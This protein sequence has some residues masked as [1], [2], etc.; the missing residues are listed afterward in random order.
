MGWKLGGQL[1]ASQVR[2]QIEREFDAE[3]AEAVAAAIAS[4]R[5]PRPI[6]ERAERRKSEAAERE[7]LL[8]SPPPLHGSATWATA[9]D[10][11]RFLKGR[12]GFNTPSS[13]LLW[14]FLEE[15]AQEPSALS[16]GMGMATC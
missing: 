4:G 8:V 11:S 7:N 3:T 15:G 13:I 2:R 5:T 12:E 9:Q 14:T 1:K 16:T 10:L 6:L